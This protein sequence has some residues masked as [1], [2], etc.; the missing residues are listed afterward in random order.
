MVIFGLF[1][2]IAF[3]S[4]K[5]NP[6]ETPTH[7]RSSLRTGRGEVAESGEI[8]ERLPDG[9]G[10][11]KAQGELQ[12]RAFFFF[13]GKRA[14][15]GWMLGLEGVL[16]MFLIFGCDLFGLPGVGRIPVLCVLVGFGDVGVVW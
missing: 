3:K 4:F 9:T 13:K 7:L 6:T 5:L 12:G 14:E 1:G 10:I 11:P 8:A 2:L 15:V 16:E